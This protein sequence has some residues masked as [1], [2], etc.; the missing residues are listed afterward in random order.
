MNAQTLEHCRANPVFL[1]RTAAYH[2][3]FAVVPCGLEAGGSLGQSLCVVPYGP[4]S[5]RSGHSTVACFP[6]QCQREG[7]GC[8]G[9]SPS[10][11][12][13][14]RFFSL[15]RSILNIDFFFG[16]AYKIGCFLLLGGFRLKHHSQWEFLT[17]LAPDSPNITL[18]SNMCQPCLCPRHLY[19]AGSHLWAGS[20]WP[21]ARLAGRECRGGGRNA[22]E[23]CWGEVCSWDPTAGG[24][25]RC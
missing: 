21:R 16:R 17:L 5:T 10:A 14:E 7:K 12:V 8:R 18:S 15:G 22:L 2:G 6:A 3:C 11:K 25:K 9:N 23:P 20:R 13:V 1:L 4:V 24:T 19:R